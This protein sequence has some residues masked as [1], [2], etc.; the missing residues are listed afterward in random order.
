MAR[1]TFLSLGTTTKI[2]MSPQKSS[3]LAPKCQIYLS[4]TTI[5]L[6]VSCPP[7]D[8]DGMWHLLE[9]ESKILN[10]ETMLTYFNN[11]DMYP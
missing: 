2:H 6:I 10:E 5:Y 9:Q 1:A 3:I 8:N 11:R 7:Y 4:P